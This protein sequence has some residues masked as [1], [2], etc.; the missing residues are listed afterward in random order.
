MLPGTVITA[1]PERWHSGSED[2]LLDTIRQQ[3]VKHFKNPEQLIAHILHECA[4]F[5]ERYKYA[6]F[7]D[8]I[9][10]V[11]EQQIARLVRIMST[12]LSENTDT[13]HVG[14]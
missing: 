1:S 13:N 8:H 14:H 12:P 11:F 3:G 6:G 5:I 10:D 4:K 2:S 7:G 9:L